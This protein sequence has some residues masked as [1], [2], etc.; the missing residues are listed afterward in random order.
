MEDIVC[1]WNHK[2]TDAYSLTFT[3]IRS[4]TI[5]NWQQRSS[6]GKHQQ[7]QLNVDAKKL[8]NIQRKGKDPQFQQ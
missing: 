6:K 7:P 5:M 2:T 8:S 1:N 4:D 3:A